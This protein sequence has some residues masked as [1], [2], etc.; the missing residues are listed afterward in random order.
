MPTVTCTFIK[1]ALAYALVG[2]L[3][4]TLGL[5]H[6][7]VRLHPLLGLLQPTALYAI[8]VG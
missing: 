5:I 7:A 2:M 4:S 6:S 8:M 3:L 1:T